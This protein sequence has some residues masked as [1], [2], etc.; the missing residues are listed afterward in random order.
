MSA[1]SKEQLDKVLHNLDKNFDAACARLFELLRCKSVSTDPAYKEDCRRAADWLAE[2]LRGIGLEAQRHD[3]EGRPIV[4]AHYKAA[5]NAPTVLF[6]G[7]YDV[8]PVDPLNLW[9]RDPFDPHIEEREG[10]KVIAARGA[11][12]DKGQV[13]TFIEALR[14][15][16]QETGCL[17]LNIKLVLEGEEESGSASLPSFLRAHKQALQADCA[18]ICDT[19]MWRRGE[20]SITMSLRGSVCEEVIIHA[21]GRD[22]HSGMYGGAA[23]NP[24][25]VLARILADLHDANGAVALP[26][27]YDGVKETEAGLLEEWQQLGFDE[28]NFL[29]PVG[30]KYAAGEKGRSLAEL[31]W[32]R[33]TAEVNGI[34]GGYEGEGFKTVIPAAAMAKV[35]FRLVPGQNPLKIRDSFRAFVCARLPQ[36]CTAE[37]HEHGAAPALTVS[38]DSPRLKRAQAALSEEWSRPAVLTGS[39]GSIPIAN[40]FRDILGIEPLFIGFALDDDCIHSPNE[41]YDVESFCKGQR[42]WARILAEFANGAS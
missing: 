24:I 6:Y 23:A 16:G 34:S 19:N 7:H 41:K 38:P 36:D 3:T 21:A 11:S 35:S 9:R 12:D 30:L 28:K 40:D 5:A 13:M 2:D 1:V 22:L 29:A 15:Y 26:H 37:F 14:A 10:H 33:P 25:H 18:L 32:T 27:F 31:V 42:S 20:P 17:P 39:G 8:Q 4:T